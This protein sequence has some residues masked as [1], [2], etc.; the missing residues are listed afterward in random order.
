MG[1]LLFVLAIAGSLYVAKGQLSSPGANVKGQHS[2]E[3]ISELG[4]PVSKESIP[5]PT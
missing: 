2:T 1:N 3:V 5:R 4:Q